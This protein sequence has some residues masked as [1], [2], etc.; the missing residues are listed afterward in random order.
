MSEFVFPLWQEVATFHAL[1]TLFLS[2]SYVANG[3]QIRSLYWQYYNCYQ[4]KIKKNKYK[5][6][7]VILQSIGIIASNRK[8]LKQGQTSTPVD[9]LVDF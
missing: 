7:F 4:K 1:H 5:E 9:I 2:I 8:I 6:K 3:R